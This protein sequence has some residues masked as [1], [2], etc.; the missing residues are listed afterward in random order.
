[1]SA[2]QYKVNDKRGT[3]LGYASGNPLYEAAT[4]TIDR[5]PA[6]QVD[7][8][9]RQNLSVFGWRQMMN[10]ARQI[11]ANFP[12]IAGLVDQM[13]TYSIGQGFN[14]QSLVK[15][16]KKAD[17]YE[18]SIYE[19]DKICNVKGPNFNFKETLILGQ[20]TMIRDGDSNV[21]LTGTNPGG[22]DDFPLI[23]NIPTHRI[24]MRTGSSLQIVPD[25]KYEGFIIWNG[26]IQTDT[27][28]AI[29]YRIYLNHFGDSEF[30]DISAD[31]LHLFFTPNNYEDSRGL[32]WLKSCI[33]DIKDIKDI[34]DWLKLVVKGESAIT[35]A[36]YNETGTPPN[37][38][39]QALLQRTDQTAPPSAI[40]PDVQMM[41]GGTIRYLKYNKEKI[42]SLSTSRPSTNAMDFQRE[43]LRGACNSLNWPIELYDADKIGGAPSRQR[44]AQAIKTLEQ[45][46]GIA[47]RQASIIH[48]YAIAKKIKLGELEPDVDWY[49]MYHQRPR[50]LTVDQGYDIKADMELVKGGFMSMQWLCDKYGEYWEEV[51]QQRVDEE[52]GWQERCAAASTGGIEVEVDNVRMIY[53]NPIPETGVELSDEEKTQ[54]AQI[55]GVEAVKG[56]MDAYGVGVRA[57]ALTPNDEDEN[58]F[59]QRL[60]LP[61]A[62]ENVKKAWSE[63]EGVRR[64]ITLVGRDG[65]IGNQPAQGQSKSN[66]KIEQ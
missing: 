23:Q 38:I 2:P 18:E 8:D 50:S 41:D 31:D 64:P 60:N 13:A 28:R 27:G 35:L 56:E 63:D 43:I 37:S 57:G 59:R 20:K 7:R 49:K 51:Q 65:T 3:S 29:A 40:N 19:W 1:M 30:V 16:K 45:L 34:R 22:D 39:R 48:R 53:P 47:E 52:R 14:M 58:N 26:V 11:C 66:G 6:P 25:G 32:T 36:E 15:D 62:N 17:K 12:P 9:D 21:L 10:A 54:Q 61:P 24:G 46:Q 44:L 5:K 42:E 4:W 55:A 33:N